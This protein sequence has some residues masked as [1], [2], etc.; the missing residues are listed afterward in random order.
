M[1]RRTVTTAVTLLVLAA[2]LVVGLLVGAN[3]LFAPLPETK[4]TSPTT[5]RPCD[6][7]SVAKG[8]RVTT[9]QVQVS[10]YNGG[11]R[12]GLA[13]ET[14]SALTKRGFRQGKIGNAPDG[15]GIKRAQVW[16]TRRHD[17]GARLAAAQFGK[18]TRVFFKDVDLGPG[19]DVLV[20]D[21]FTKLGPATRAVVAQHPFS[22]CRKPRT[23]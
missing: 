6:K 14:M 21:D 18:G 5:S 10:V 11:S 9:R 17:P 3:A 19:V 15:A 23:G 2:I 4:Q 22:V 13:D 12:A 8:Q 16:T 1:R 20:G 7:Q